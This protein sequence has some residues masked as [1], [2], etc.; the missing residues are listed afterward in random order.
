MRR[1]V[2]SRQHDRAA[3]DE[4]DH[5]RRHEEPERTAIA[6][7]VHVRSVAEAPTRAPRATR[8]PGTRPRR[9]AWD[10]ARHAAVADVRAVRVSTLVKIDDRRDRPEH[11]IAGK[12]RSVEEKLR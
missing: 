6:V 1:G 9:R 3:A 11:S 12:V 7:A 10:D 2:T 5:H 8:V 4:R